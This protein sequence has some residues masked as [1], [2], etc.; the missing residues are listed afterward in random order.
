MPKLGEEGCGNDSLQYAPPKCELCNGLQVYP[1][2]HMMWVM[3]INLGME[4]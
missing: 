3:I 2:L 4:C 1:D